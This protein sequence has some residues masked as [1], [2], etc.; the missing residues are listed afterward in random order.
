MSENY[1]DCCDGHNPDSGTVELVKEKCCSREAM[2]DLAAVFKLMGDPVRISIL[3]ALSMSDLCVCD[4]AELLDMSHSA[5]SH[6][7]RLLRTARMVRFEKHGRKA[8]YSLSD[9]H[10][11]TIMRTALD[12][13]HGTGCPPDKED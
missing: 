7:L 4:L 6:Q 10:V 5:V 8:V 1:I 11:E 9:S 13:M 3:H 2:Q 12:H